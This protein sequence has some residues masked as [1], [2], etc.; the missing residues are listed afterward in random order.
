MKGGLHLSLI[1]IVSIC[2]I[3]VQS[4]SAEKAHKCKTD[5]IV[6]C[7]NA[8]RSEVDKQKSVVNKY[9]SKSVNE[10]W[11]AILMKYD[12]TEDA[13]MRL[14]SIK[15]RA[16]FGRRICK[17]FDIKVTRDSETE[18]LLSIGFFNQHGEGPFKYH[19]S[20]KRDN[21]VWYINATNLDMAL[22]IDKQIDVSELHNYC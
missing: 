15:S 10:E 21:D 14:N 8:Y 11:L 4:E 18:A 19:L 2:S 16:L 12:S 17:T 9:F 13:M 6:N 20:Y 7:F 22:S 5:D 1:I 3:S